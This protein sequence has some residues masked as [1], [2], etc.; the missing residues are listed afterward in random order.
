MGEA[1]KLFQGAARLYTENQVRGPARK[2]RGA[3]LH[4]LL[5]FSL[6]LLCDPFIN[7]PSQP[8]FHLSQ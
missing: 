7:D 2:P 4:N 1:A 8:S 5:E 3:A 6:T